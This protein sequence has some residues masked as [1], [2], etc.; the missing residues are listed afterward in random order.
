MG[1]DFFDFGEEEIDEGGFEE[2]EDLWDR[3][4]D[5]VFDLGTGEDEVEGVGKILEENDGGR[6]GVFQVMV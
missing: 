4:E 3:G 6:G 2:G 1:E 5:E